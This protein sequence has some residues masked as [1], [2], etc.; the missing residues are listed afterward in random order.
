MKQFFAILLLLSLQTSVIK[1][2]GVPLRT[3]EITTQ[4]AEC[5]DEADDDIDDDCAGLARRNVSHKVYR[6][7]MQQ[8]ILVAA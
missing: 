6:I 8:P 5:I 3:R 7:I 2:Q 1:C 4:E